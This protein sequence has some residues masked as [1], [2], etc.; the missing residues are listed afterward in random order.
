MES[1]WLTRNTLPTQ[2]AA[3]HGS[4]WIDHLRWRPRLLQRKAP[5]RGPCVFGRVT[6]T[7]SIATASTRQRWY[8]VPAQL[9]WPG[10]SPGEILCAK[11]Y[12]WGIGGPRTRA[13]KLARQCR[14]DTICIIIG[15][16]YVVKDLVN[17]AELNGRIVVALMLPDD[18]DR[19]MVK[20]G[21]R[22]LRLLQKHLGAPVQ[23]NLCSEFASANL[24]RA[25]GCTASSHT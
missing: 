2:T 24:G 16:Q 12:S 4:H 18:D 9:P 10:I 21:D 20:S 3:E 8:R 5:L 19:V 11:C 23:C 22:Y 1:H 15:S 25:L 6:S 7:N 17:S 14:D 13:R